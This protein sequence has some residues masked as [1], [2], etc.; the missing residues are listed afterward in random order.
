MGLFRPVAGKLY[1]YLLLYQILLIS[2]C[3][4]E[5]WLH[6][7]NR[8]Q[9]FLFSKPSL[10]A[11][12]PA[13]TL[14]QWI[15]GVFPGLKAAGTWSL[16]FTQ[17]I[18]DVKNEWRYNSTPPYAFMVCTETT[19]LACPKYVYADSSKEDETGG[20]LARVTEISKRGDV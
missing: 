14:V 3:A 11:L 9:I 17:Y 13:Y 16:P 5:S 7:H 8:Q 19:V 2:V 1:L 6:S 12:G 4:E 20:A 10:L 15:K 18:A